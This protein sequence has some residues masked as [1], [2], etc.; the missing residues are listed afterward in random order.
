MNSV[1]STENQRGRAALFPPYC[2]LLR[3]H[4]LYPLLAFLVVAGLVEYFHWDLALADFLYRLEGDH[5]AL[6]RH[7]LTSTIVHEYGRH[8]V[9]LLVLAVVGLIIRDW[10]AGRERQRAAD[11]YLL[12]CFA[13]T[14]LTVSLL[15]HLTHV[16]CPWDLSRYGG[17]LA[18]VPIFSPLPPG[19]EAGVCFPAGHASSAYAWVALYY[20]FRVVSPRYRWYGLAFGLALG[21]VFDIGQQLRGAHFFSHGLWTLGIA[22]CVATGGYLLTLNRKT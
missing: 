13:V 10:R 20:Y 7:V 8:L 14:T 5:W 18:Y 21:L 11:L 15:R 16:T 19:K 1:N 9:Q 22:W 2:G 4:L 3:T 12:A 17:E 6:K